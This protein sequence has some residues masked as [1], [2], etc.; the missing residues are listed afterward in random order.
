MPHEMNILVE[1]VDGTPHSRIA[2]FGITTVTKNLDSMQPATV[3]T[4]HTPRWSA[5]E[6]MR[7]ENPSRAS[8]VYSFA[9]IMIEVHRVWSTIRVASTYRCPVLIQVLSGQAPFSNIKSNYLVVMS[10][11]EGK[12]PPRPENPSCSDC[13]WSLIKRCWAQDPRLRPDIR[14]VSQTFSSFSLN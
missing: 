12:R 14:E 9:M 7:E 6:V 13:L 3:Q 10:V 8:D 5:P 2:D 1:V 4:V 11:W